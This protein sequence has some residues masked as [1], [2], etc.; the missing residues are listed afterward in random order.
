MQQQLQKNGIILLFCDTF[1]Q[2]FVVLSV[3][4]CKLAYQFALFATIYN[5]QHSNNYSAITPK[6]WYCTG[7]GKT[8]L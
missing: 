4:D 7:Q 3:P 8:L 6:G 2:Y 5:L 1:R